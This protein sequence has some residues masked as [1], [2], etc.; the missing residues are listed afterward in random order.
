MR[1]NS[2]NDVAF[3]CSKYCAGDPADSL[4]NGTETTVT[5]CNDPCEI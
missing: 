2:G 4:N 1:T 3:S 5:L